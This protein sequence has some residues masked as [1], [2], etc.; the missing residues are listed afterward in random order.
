LLRRSI[1]PAVAAG[2]LSVTLAR[3]GAAFVVPGHDAVEAATYKRL[4]ATPKVDD[5]RGGRVSGREAIAFLIRRGFLARPHCFEAKSPQ[6][7]AA[8]RE[9]SRTRPLGS[10]PAL[11]SSSADLVSERQFATNGQCF[12]FMAGTSYAWTTPIDPRTGFFAGFS[13]DAYFRCTRLLTELF[14]ETLR[15]PAGSN[16]DNRGLYALMHAVTDAF[17]AAHVERDAR[18]RILYLKPWRARGSLSYLVPG[19]GA[20]LRF[21]AGPTHHD[22]IDDRDEDFVR[23]E[24][25]ACAALENAYAITEACLG[26]RGRRAVDAL[27]DLML[28]VHACAREIEAGIPVD[29]RAVFVAFAGRHLANPFAAPDT[30]PPFWDEREWNSAYVFGFR[31]RDRPVPGAT[32]LSVLAGASLFT[33]LTLPL[34]PFFSIEAGCRR[35]AGACRLE[36]GVDALTLLLPVTEGFAI[37]ATPLS[38]VGSPGDAPELSIG[39][40]VVRA[41]LHLL[42]ALW[43]SVSGPR[44]AWAHQRFDAELLAVSMGFSWNGKVPPLETSNTPPERPVRARADSRTLEAEGGQEKWTPAPLGASYRRRATTFVVHLAGGT[45]IPDGQQGAYSIGG[46]EVLFDRDRWD[47]RAGFAIGARADTEYRPTE[48]GDHYGAVASPVAR[49]YL[50]PNRLAIEAD[51]AMID[52]GALRRKDGRVDPFFDAALG[53]CVAAIPLGHVEFA[54]ETPRFSYRTASRVPG[55]NLG[56]RLGLALQ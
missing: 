16:E 51:P 12:H 32:D 34:V 43:L 9:E 53:G 5:G 26:R 23:R 20:G 13:R 3:S 24:D 52:A 11:H 14:V 30:R 48:E 50:V 27:E 47:R 2:A 6:E 54:F 19:H 25:P 49:F 7:D 18:D 31:F 8:C 17:S 42:D 56:V 39:A 40:N 44:Y 28:T 45:V 4:V 15:D 1:W 29:V 10:W 22:V 46:L 21:V 55:T 36:L 37:G 35:V 33:D 41:D 38:I